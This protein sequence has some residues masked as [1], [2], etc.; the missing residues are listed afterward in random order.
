MRS[1]T[2]WTGLAFGLALAAC[3]R[4][5]VAADASSAQ[6]MAAAAGA[7]TVGAR[8]APLPGHGFAS[9]PDRGELLAYPVDVVRRDGAYTWH[10]AAL[11]EAHAL[12]AIASGHLRVTTPSGRLLDVQYDRHVEHPS[13][14]WTWIGHVAGQP[15]EQTILTFGADAAFGT[16]A[17]PGTSPLRLTVRNGVAWLV[18]TDP[19][20]VAG[21]INAATRPQRPD[22]LTPPKTAALADTFAAP[23]TSAAAPVM[24]SAAAS[25]TTTVDLLIGYTPQFATDNGGASGATTRLNFLVDVTNAAYVNSQIDAQVRL[26]GTLQVNYADATSN[27]DTLQKLTGYDSNTHQQIAT[28]PAF[29][30]LRAAREQYGADVVSLVRSFRDPENGGCGIAWLIGGGLQGI[31]TQDAFFGYSVVS[32][33]R[34]VGTDG[35]TY[36]CLDETLAHEL[37][38]NMGA[39]H[40]AETAKGTDGV[41]NNP[42]DYGAF[43]YSFGYKSTAP[44]AG[45]ANGFYTVMAYGDTGQHIYRIFSDPRSTFCGNYVCGSATGADNARTLSQTIGT[46]AAF[47]AAVVVQPPPITSIPRDDVNADGKTDLLWSNRTS[48]LFVHWLMNGNAIAASKGFAISNIFTAIGSGDF[49]GNG[50]TDIV[51][52]TST[53]DLYLWLGTGTGYTSKFLYHLAAGWKLVGTADVNGDGKSDL[54]WNNQAKGTF[55]HWVMNGNVITSSAAF[56]IGSSFSGIGVGDFDGNG[57]ADVLW[58][59]GNGNVYMWLG[60]GTAYVNKFVYRLVSGWKLVGAADVDGDGKTDMLWHHQTSGVF[61]HWV[62]NG[63]TIASSKGFSISPSLAPIGYGDFDGNNH[64]DVL[65]TTSSGDL[66]TWLGNGTTYAGAFTY[67]LAGGWSAVP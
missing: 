30:A 9:L 38:H 34:D 26:V 35:K 60:T 17:Q 4:A 12:A 44:V 52:T 67:R 24:A 19:R 59:D 23:T 56:A 66:Y 54:L 27:D 5:P 3:S 43:T 2:V 51:W 7:S 57:H 36:F 25:P 6:A 21:I 45:G 11:S 48:G 41:L 29:N 14:D 10:R 22:Y 18:E 31:S 20:M 49:D 40:D 46:V 62:M 64:A 53:G 1:Y 55:V 16:I 37:G 8:Q 33:G 63:P 39:Q 13:G 50:H 15:G 65:W 42:D 61:V 32:D 28:D 47:R 58:M